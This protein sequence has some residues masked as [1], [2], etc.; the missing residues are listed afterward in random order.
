MIKFYVFIFTLAGP[1]TALIPQ[2]EILFENRKG[3][4]EDDRYR[5]GLIQRLGFLYTLRTAQRL[6]APNSTSFSTIC[7]FGTFF[8]E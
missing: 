3:E 5:K 6:G 7:F 4:N 1:L 2:L 8:L